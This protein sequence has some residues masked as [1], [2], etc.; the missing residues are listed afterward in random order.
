MH[1]HEIIR[2]VEDNRRLDGDE[3][4]A[5]YRQ[6]PTHVLG[7][8]ADSVRLRKHPGRTVTYIIDRNVNYTNVCV[9]KC[10]FCAFYRDVGSSEGYVL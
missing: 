10:N 7:R 4:L 6:A 3:A 8:L 5:L 9:A 2:R 1:I